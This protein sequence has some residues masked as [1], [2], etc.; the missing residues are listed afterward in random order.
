M[1]KYLILITFLFFIV[2]TKAQD[3]QSLTSVFG[4]ICQTDSIRSSLA[5]INS[6][7]TITFYFK[8][9]DVNTYGIIEYEFEDFTLVFDTGSNLLFAGKAYG[10]IDQMDFSKKKAEI[11][12]RIEGLGDR[13]KIGKFETSTYSFIQKDFKWLLKSV[14][15]N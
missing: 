13:K 15:Y 1:K 8:T 7:S 6:D 14:K 5:S 11:T 3:E 12:V 2:L 4:R 10:S 9:P